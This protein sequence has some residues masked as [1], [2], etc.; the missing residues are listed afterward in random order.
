MK[1]LIPV[2]LVVCL[3]LLSASAMPVFATEVPH[4]PTNVNITVV[5]PDPPKQ[6][7]EPAPEPEPAVPTI[8]PITM[9]PIDVTEVRD[10]GNWQIIRTYSL[11]PD[12]SPLDIPQGSFERSGWTFTLTDI[13]RRESS[14]AETREHTETITLDTATNDLAQILALLNNTMDYRS[15]DGFVGILALDVSSIKVETA[16][17]RTTS[18]TMTVT[19]EYPH[20]SNTDTGLVPKTVTDR[21]TTYTLAGVDW[22][23]GNYVTVDYERIPEYYTAVASYTATGSRTAV[24]GYITTATYTGSLGRLSQGTTTYVAFFLGEEIRTPLEMI[25][26]TPTPTPEPTPEPAIPPCEEKPVEPD[27]EPE[28][29]PEDE[30]AEASESKDGTGIPLAA[31]LLVIPF[32]ALVTGG[33][34]YMI[35]KKKGATNHEKT[36]NP[37]AHPDDDGGSRSSRD[38]G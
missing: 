1:K 29:I 9:F 4:E 5:M 3:F 18:H 26:P 36:D 31:L 14:N 38:G 20:L 6:A 30:P 32:T 24:T 33:A 28:I 13:I 16:G 2:T 21:G 25:T 35:T 12:E 15:D 37:A 27:D 22:R 34:Y 11:L 19:R 8:E 17:T 23:V 7:E 10:G